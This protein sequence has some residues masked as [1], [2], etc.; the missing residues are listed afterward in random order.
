MAEILIGIPTFNRL[1]NLKVCIKEIKRHTIQP[2]DLIVA[3][4]HSSDGTLEWLIESGIRYETGE[5]RGGGRNKNRIF[6]HYR[7][8]K[9]IFVFED[10]YKPIYIGWEKEF[11]DA[12]NK[13]KL[14]ALL[15]YEKE[16][17]E[18]LHGVKYAFTDDLI[19]A[20]RF[21][22]AVALYDSKAIE[23]VGGV[24][25]K[26]F[27]YGHSIAEHFWRMQKSKLIPSNFPDA[28]PHLA[29]S[30]DYI[31]NQY[32]AIFT[33][34]KIRKVQSDKNVE[35]TQAIQADCVKNNNYFIPIEL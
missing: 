4:D 32:A 26:F 2:Y 19:W 24:N 21:E 12:M 16:H 9:Y 35:L 29:K 14:P 5:N 34:E 20:N 1:K 6:K 7:G 13:Y 8:Y 17:Y 3:D 11:I 10:D 31:V 27:G 25:P 28:T 22:P 15:Y 18:S 33:D 30:V 23:K